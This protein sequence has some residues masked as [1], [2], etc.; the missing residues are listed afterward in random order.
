MKI[1]CARLL[2]HSDK[3]DTCIDPGDATN[4]Q[5]ITYWIV[6]CVL[7]AFLS[8]TALFGNSVILITFWRTSTLHSVANILLSSLA[9]SDFAVGL[10]AQPLFIAIILSRVF[11]VYQ[12][13]NV[14][15][16]FLCCASFITVTAITIDR[17]LVLQLHLRY[18]EIVTPV[19]VTWAV[20]FIWV[21]SGACTLLLNLKLGFFDTA[22]FATIFSILLGNFAVYFKIY[23]I[24]RRHQTQIQQQ[25]HQQ[26]HAKHENIFSVTR[27]KKTALNTFLVYMLL[28]CCYMPYCIALVSGGISREVYFTMITLIFINSSL[29]PL[30]Y[31]W[32]DRAIRRAV[33]QMF[34]H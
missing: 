29:N 3:N 19:R 4:E 34:C 11:T 32:Q 31:C 22:A 33:K 27:F 25:H 15:S 23:L 16:Y 5:S 28:L 7:N 10:V 12:V 6:I 13:Y 1:N 30:L 21:F 17:L 2:N 24:V 26:R 18:H 14:M 8:F 9:V 20:I